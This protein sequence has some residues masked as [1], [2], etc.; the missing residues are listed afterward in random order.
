[1]S[2]MTPH[3]MRTRCGLVGLYLMM[4]LTACAPLRAVPTPQALP[5]PTLYESPVPAPEPPAGKLNNGNLTKWSL[6]LLEALG[7]ANADRAALR[8]WVESIRGTSP[9]P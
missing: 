2:A 7:V 6:E 5:N 9:K 8:A 1:M 4:S 3:S